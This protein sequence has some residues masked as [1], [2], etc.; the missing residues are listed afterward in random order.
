MSQL[1]KENDHLGFQNK[2]LLA[3]CTLSESDYISLCKRVGTKPKKTFNRERLENTLRSISDVDSDGEYNIEW[4]I[5]NNNK[6]RR[7]GKEHK[8]LHKEIDLPKHKREL[9]TIRKM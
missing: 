5:E 7:M 8:I 1:M 9:R 6:H 4:S 2:I 3:M